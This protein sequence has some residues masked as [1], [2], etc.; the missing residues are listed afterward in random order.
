MYTKI[1]NFRPVLTEKLTMSLAR[2]CVC[3][4]IVTRGSDQVC[5]NDEC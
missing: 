1:L 3:P 4:L 2:N 5:E